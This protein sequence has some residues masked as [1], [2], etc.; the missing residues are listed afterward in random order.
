MEPVV[1][2]VA[3]GVVVAAVDRLIRMSPLAQ[4]DLVDFVLT[5]LGKFFPEPTEAEIDA[6]IKEIREDIKEGGE[7]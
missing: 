7:K 3:G 4:N 5:L 6:L 2:F 1:L